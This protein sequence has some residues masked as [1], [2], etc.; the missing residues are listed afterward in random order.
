VSDRPAETREIHTRLMKCALEVEESRAYWS[1]F[2]PGEPPPPVSRVF[3][4]Y[5]F[6]A[7]SVPRIR[8]LLTNLRARFDAFPAAARVLHRWSAAGMAPDVRRVI[9][10]WHLQLSDPLYRAFSGDYL[11]A[12]RNERQSVT[13]DA[14]V[15]WMT[16]VGHEH[17]TMGTR[18]QFASK[19][20]SCAYAA[21]LV[22]STRDPRPLGVPRLDDDALAY[23][24]Y[25]LRDVTFEGTPLA[26]PYLASLGLDGALLED[27]LRL[28]PSLG[29]SRMGALVEFGWRHRNLEAWADSWLPPAPLMASEN[30][31]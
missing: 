10:H 22:G 11:V 4:E 14:V 20:L 7:R 15:A 21:G 16:K 2:E 18:I 23:L 29:F 3:E 31:R 17:W 12:R 9:C 1:R 19:L 24:M 25:L 30:P 26:N 27:R 5:W 8:V 13:H 28:L 6:G